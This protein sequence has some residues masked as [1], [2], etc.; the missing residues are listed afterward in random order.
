MWHPRT[1]LIT[2]PNLGTPAFSRM[3]VVSNDLTWFSWDVNRPEGRDAILDRIAGAHW[4]L[5]VSIYSDLILPPAALAAIGLPINIHPAL[6]RIRGVGHDIVPLV[7][8]HATVGATLH[9]MD[10]KVDSGEILAVHEVALP[11]SHTR[12]SLRALNQ[13]LSITL[14]ERFCAVL[15]EAAD[16]AEVELGLRSCGDTFGHQWGRYY[17]R[18]CVEALQAGYDACQ[19]QPALGRPGL[20]TEAARGFGASRQ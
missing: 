9:R 17:S 16:P 3:S 2:D 7:E 5:A 12:G 19:L 15:K 18:A 13:S 4:D 1:L 6:P 14:L 20:S 8:K 11:P 10:P